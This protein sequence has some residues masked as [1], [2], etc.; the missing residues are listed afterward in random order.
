MVRKKSNLLTD[1]SL[2]QVK[3]LVAIKERIGVLEAQ[4]SKLEN[5]LKKIEGE[6]SRLFNDQTGMS[7]VK[8]RKVGRKKVGRVK[9]KAT[10]KAR[11]KTVRKAAAGKTGGKQTLED[12]V[13][14]LISRKGKPVSFQDLLNTITTKRLV[15]TRSTNFDNVLRRTLSTSKKIKRVS[16]GVYGV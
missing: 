3:K 16:R 10:R 13:V 14:K 12:V 1:L 15:K 6:L 7:G 11:K 8:A 5:E 2:A 4:K 9:K